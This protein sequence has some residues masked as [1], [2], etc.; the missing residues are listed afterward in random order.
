VH[1]HI[2]TVL[3]RIREEM[4]RYVMDPKNWTHS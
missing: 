3:E 1:D 4:Q 2:E